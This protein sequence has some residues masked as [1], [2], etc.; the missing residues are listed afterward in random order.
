ME[1]PKSVELTKQQVIEVIRKVGAFKGKLTERVQPRKVQETVFELEEWD[2]KIGG[3][4]PPKE[5]LDLEKKVREADEARGALAKQ[6]DGKPNQEEAA[7]AERAFSEILA[8]FA[9][10]RDAWHNKPV[11][12]PWSKP[13][14]RWIWEQFRKELE[15]ECTLAREDVLVA[16]GKALGKSG[17]IEDMIAEAIEESEK[18]D[19]KEE[20]PA[21][22]APAPQLVK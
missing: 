9:A 7:K 17:E 12:V 8:E 20:E 21:P 4:P 16:L 1:G 13:E 22:V 2:E 14:R 11:F 6:A 5:I 10:K 3:F 18:Q 19:E 15:G